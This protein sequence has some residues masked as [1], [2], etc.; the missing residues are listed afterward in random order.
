[1]VRSRTYQAVRRSGLACFFVMLGRVETK[2][3]LALA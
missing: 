1:M 2:N 3:V